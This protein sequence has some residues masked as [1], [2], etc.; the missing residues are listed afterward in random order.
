[1]IHKTPGIV[2]HSFRY[3]ETSVIARVYTR[4]LGMQS[5]LVPGVRKTRSK[6]KSNLF[7]PLTPVDMVVYYKGKE[8]LSRIREITCPEPF[9][10]IPYDI[11]KSSIAM[12]LSEILSKSFKEQDP[13]P[14]LFDFIKE[15]LQYLDQTKARVSDFHLVFLMQLSAYLGFQPRN[16]YDALHCYFNLREGQF[17]RSFEGSDI[18][19]DKEMSRMFHQINTTSCA[20]LDQLHVPAELRRALLKKTIAYFQY[21]HTGMSEI[22][23]LG[24]LEAV[25]KP[26]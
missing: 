25:L 12:F 16:N 17:E 21:H 20:G 18:C 19:L 14:L 6:I 7:R 5:Y 2:L 11:L 9:T 10:S 8:G 4:E 13:N 15:A 3:G 1:M 26:S 24:V 23:S 22:K